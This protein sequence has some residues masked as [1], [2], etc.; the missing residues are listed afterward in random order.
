MLKGGDVVP[1]DIVIL[2]PYQ[3]QVQEICKRLRNWNVSVR[4]V[5]SVD[6]FQG[7]Q[8][9]LICL[10]TVRCNVSGTLGFAGDARRLSVA[11]TRAQRGL[12]IFGSQ[13]TLTAQD[14]HGTWTPFFQFFEA[15]GW[16]QRSRWNAP[17][18]AKLNERERSLSMHRDACSLQSCI[19]YDQVSGC[20]SSEVC[21]GS[22]PAPP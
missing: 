15:R 4:D 20:S 14:G 16:I 1:D 10:S 22:G 2:A 3:K 17:P 19:P 12:L 21:L 18:E 6:R 7:S 8:A 11:M 9:P 5:V 13:W